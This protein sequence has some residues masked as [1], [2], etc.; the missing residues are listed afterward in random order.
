MGNFF[1]YLKKNDEFLGTLVAIITSLLFIYNTFSQASPI[2]KSNFLIITDILNL[3]VLFVALFA[4]RNQK[5]T[6]ESAEFTELLPILNCTEEVV[7]GKQERI[8]ELIF[9]L[10][11]SIKWFILVLSGFYFLQLFL[12]YTL[13]ENTDTI[14]KSMENKKTMYDL[15]SVSSTI[16][17]AESL[18]AASFLSLEFLMNTTNL[19]S[20]ALL[21]TAF[22]VL[23]V[24]TIRD[25]N[26][27]W[28]INNQ[29]PLA[30]AIAITILNLV[31]YFV[32]LGYDL[33]VKSNVI[34]LLGGLYNG[35]AMTLLF[36]RFISME[37][38][39][40]KA[41]KSFERNFYF[42]GITFFLPL[43]I[44]VQPMYGLFY[45]LDSDTTILFKSVI[46]LSCFFGKMVFLF[47]VFTMINK[48]WIHAYLLVSL[49]SNRTI[50]LIAEK[51]KDVDLFSS[52]EK[53]EDLSPT[54]SEKKKKKKKKKK[55]D[56]KGDKNNLNNN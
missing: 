21:F 5:L 9:Q 45:S 47:F 46:F 1:S 34:R 48:K 53:E 54:N 3:V 18:D 32:P 22:Q 35:I 39:F 2:G 40:Q 23:F 20:A 11:K 33:N 42:Y 49:T 8:N 13:I 24:K 10:I 30:V 25:D 14:I 56:S 44:V 36:S 37:F 31:V 15:F 16:T 28:N 26:K 7:K 6:I 19:F 43:Y 38:F 51:I 50:E 4:I 17:E 55:D 52:T 41:T 27:T 29:I 12:D